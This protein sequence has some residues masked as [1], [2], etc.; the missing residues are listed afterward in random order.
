MSHQEW[1]GGSLSQAVAK[2]SQ[3]ACRCSCGGVLQEETLSSVSHFRGKTQRFEMYR[4][5]CSVC[6]HVFLDHEPRTAL[7]QNTAR[8]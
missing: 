2:P 5:R 1:C 6:R 4:Y 3:G 7:R 8:A